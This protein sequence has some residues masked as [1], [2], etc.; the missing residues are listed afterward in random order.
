M[1]VIMTL[2]TNLTALSFKP[3]ILSFEILPRDEY[4]P[5]ITLTNSIRR[6]EGPEKHFVLH[7]THYS[8]KYNEIVHEL[9]LL[10]DL[11]NSFTCIIHGNVHQLSEL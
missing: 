6:V 7:M 4:P 9:K 8:F 2:V 11:D 10:S 3:V 5:S 1:I